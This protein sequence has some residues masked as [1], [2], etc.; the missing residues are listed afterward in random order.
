[1]PGQ[2]G[3]KRHTTQN[4]KVHSVD[5]ERNLL[6]IVGPVPGAKGSTVE[7]RPAVKKS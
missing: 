1:M 3:N 5:T 4:C 7:V 6:F 2:M